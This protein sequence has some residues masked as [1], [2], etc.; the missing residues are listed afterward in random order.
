MF[1]LKKNKSVPIDLNALPEH[2]AIIM[3]GNGRWAKSRGLMRQAGHAA[4]CETFRKIGTYC[5]DIGIKYLTVYAF[6]TENWKR[7][8][9]EV[10]GIMRLF[11]DYM[12][13]ALEK[14]IDDNIA[15]HVLGDYSAFSPE[16]LALINNVEELSK[17]VTSGLQASL[18][19]NY[20]GRSEILQATKRIVSDV[21][22]GILDES[23]LDEAVFSSYLYTKTLPEP[24]IIIRPGREM[25]IS[26]FL[27][28]QSAYSE[29]YFTD[30]LWPD[31]DENELNRA[32][33]SFQQRMRRFGGI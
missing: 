26:N 11:Q 13:E 30:T 22:A 23:K 15:I 1:A 7:P 9:D 20:G 21:K 25:R 12:N 10:N 19:M 31:F 17:E 2:I 28:W 32:I 29:Y 6:S 33:A 8:A 3:D 5:R 14:M 24:D 18:C 16:M 27:L 4:G